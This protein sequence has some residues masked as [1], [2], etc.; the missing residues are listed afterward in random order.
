VRVATD[1]LDR[2]V[3]QP[4]VALTAYG[5]QIPRFLATRSEAMAWAE[6][7]GWQFPGSKIIQKTAKGDRVIWRQPLMEAAA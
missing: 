5:V 1:D 4:Y 3:T 2:A 7:H 6:A